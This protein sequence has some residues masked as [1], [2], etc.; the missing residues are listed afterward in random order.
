M[1]PEQGLLVI[2]EQLPVELLVLVIRAVLRI[3][4]PQRTR[5]IDKFRALADLKLL[6]LRLCLL[7]CY[8]LLRSFVL[9]LC[10]GCLCLFFL[11]RLDHLNDNIVRTAL[12]LLDGLCLLGVLHRQIDLGRHEAAVLVNHLA[13]TIVIRELHAVLRQM[14]GNGRSDLL[15]V[16]L[17][18]GELAA[19]VALP[20][21]GL[22][23][24]LIG[25]RIDGD[26]R[27]YHE[28]RIEAQSKVT[29][30]LI[31]V[32]LIL[33]FIHE[34][35]RT[36]EGNVVD[37]FL[38]LVRCH[39]K[40]VIGNLNGLALGIQNHVDSCLPALRKLRF[41]HHFQLLQ[42]CNGIAAIGNQ[43]TIEN[44]MVTVQPFLDNREHVLAVN[45]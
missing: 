18:H 37:I 23:S 20:V 17:L 10:R 43:L 19:A 45:G 2:I 7:R 16:G 4:D 32:R 11:L 39:A 22:R 24:L 1:D 42:L 8:L 13:G 38:H 33:V 41:P 27:R 5:I 44:I 12:R 21:N 35:F 25:K 26:K 14:E 40:S 3:L 28:R 29:D 15:P 30:D 34:G 31:V 6:L 36:G 9:A